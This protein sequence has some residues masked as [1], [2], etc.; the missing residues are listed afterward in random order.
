[1]ILLSRM[2]VVV[3]AA[4]VFHVSRSRVQTYFFHNELLIKLIFYIK[5]NLRKRD[6]Q[7]VPM[8]L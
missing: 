2:T 1:M 4:N 8:C 7:P 6:R 5:Q 3:T